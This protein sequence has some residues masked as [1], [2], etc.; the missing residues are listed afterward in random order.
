MA[1]M[2]WLLSAQPGG[3]CVPDSVERELRYSYPNTKVRWDTFAGRWCVATHV[4]GYG[5]SQDF[6]WQGERGEFR[7]LPSTAEP[8]LRKLQAGI[9]LHSLGKDAREINEALERGSAEGNRRVLRQRNSE[10]LDRGR[11]CIE[12]RRKRVLGIRQTFGPLG[13]RSRHGINTGLQSAHDA[14][15]VASRQR[16]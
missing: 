16:G 14:Q 12:D 8:L 11:D 6:L 3:V 5:W 9:D 4:P 7:P 2:P 10:A 13:I 1:R 15:W